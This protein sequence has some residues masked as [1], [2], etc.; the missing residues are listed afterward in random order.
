MSHEKSILRVCRVSLPFECLIYSLYR[1]SWLLKKRKHTFK[2][3]GHPTLSAILREIYEFR[4]ISRSASN[5]SY[6]TI[7]EAMQ[8][9]YELRTKI[10]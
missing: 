4:F 10:L 9:N 2:W 6:A 5:V 3:P 8:V 7:E 1:V